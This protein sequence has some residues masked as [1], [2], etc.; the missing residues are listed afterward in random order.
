[1]QVVS[2]GVQQKSDRDLI[3]DM[4]AKLPEQP[5]ARDPPL[6]Q[7][8]TTLTFH[9][10][11]LTCRQKEL[12]VEWKDTGRFD[13]MYRPR[14]EGVQ[15]GHSSPCHA[16]LPGHPGHSVG[17]RAAPRVSPVDFQTSSAYV[18]GGFQAPAVTFGFE[19]QSAAQRIED[20]LTQLPPAPVLAHKQV[21]ERPASDFNKEIIKD[22]LAK[23]QPVTAPTVVTPNQKEAEASLCN[24]DLNE[25][26]V[27]T[28]VMVRNIP[29]MYTQEMLMEEWKDSGQFNFLHLPRDSGGTILG[30]AFVNFLKGEDAAAFKKNW[31][32]ARL[33]LSNGLKLNISFADVQGLRANLIHL[34]HRARYLGVQSRQPYILMGGKA[35]SLE[36]ALEVVWPRA[37]GT[38]S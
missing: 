6:D 7:L 12:M 32:K 21:Q 30:Y 8:L 26:E 23:I 34:R 16:G 1:M 38:P 10:S 2:F 33:G 22:V 35:V 13:F 17:A 11:P 3:Q 18:A 4:L 5:E 37:R 14:D 25:A 36:Q 28:T 19:E 15:F 31:H 20:L 24:E 9:N 27:L 29:C